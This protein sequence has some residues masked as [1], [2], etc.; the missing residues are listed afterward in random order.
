[1]LCGGGG[2]RVVTVTG[3]QATHPLLP[4][5][6]ACVHTPAAAGSLGYTSLNLHARVE[7]GGKDVMGRRTLEGRDAGGTDK[8]TWR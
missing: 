1:M 3:V 5:L 2:V 7:E 4:C 6:P 8:L